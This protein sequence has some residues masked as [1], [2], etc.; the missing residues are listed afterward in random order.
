M[1]QVRFH[2]RGGQGA[3]SP[4]PSCSRRPR[5]ARTGLRAGVP[6]LR[7]GADRRSGDVVPRRIDDKPI[8]TR[9]P[10]TAPDALVIQDPT[11]LHHAGLLDG[12]RPD[13]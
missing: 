2:G 11:L 3:S 7:L 4:P 8:R 13:G 12:L 1:F 10:V 9:E 5:S 6:D